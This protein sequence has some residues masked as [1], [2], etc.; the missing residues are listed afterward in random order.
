MKELLV[1][2]T[3]F[4]GMFNNT[5]GENSSTT[6]TLA[7][8]MPSIES[9]KIEL[10]LCKCDVLKDL[11]QKNLCYAKASEDVFFCDRVRDD[12]LKKQCYTAVTSH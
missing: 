1:A 12:E 4:L 7:S 5:P 2:L 11:D 10:E 3:L 6:T 8:I 9:H